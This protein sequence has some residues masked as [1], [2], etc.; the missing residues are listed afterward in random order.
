MRPELL[1]IVVAA[2]IVFLMVFFI[3]K[4][5]YRK[6]VQS[7]SA[8]QEQRQRV[9]LLSQA[10]EDELLRLRSQE[11]LMA[12]L[13]ERKPNFDLWSF[14]NTMLTETK[15]KDRANLENYKPRTDKKESLEDVTMVQLKLAG[16]TLAEMVDLLHKVYA[17]NNLVL[18]YRLEYLRVAGESKGLECNI[19]FLTPKGSPVA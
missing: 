6:Y 2:A 10:K 3:A 7:R 19:I 14:M 11:Q 4:G 1:V 16:I 13:K 5:P 12:R 9:K 8:V 18:T 17:S 15:L